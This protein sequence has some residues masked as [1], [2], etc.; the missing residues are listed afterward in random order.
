LSEIIARRGLCLVLAAPSGGGK[1]SIAQALLAQEPALF[2]SVSVTTRA[3]RP[4]EI[5][6]KHYYFRDEPAFMAL[7]EG[8]GLLEWARKFGRCYGTPRAAVETALAAGR[9]VLFDIDWQGFRQLRAAIPDD[10]V[11]IF[12]LPPSLAALDARLR[13]RRGDDAAEI[14]RRMAE[15]Q[16]EIAHWRE[17]DHVIINDALDDAVADVRAILRAGRLATARQ[18]GLDAFAGAFLS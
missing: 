5:E 4:G 17:F 13:A 7:A 18:T 14:A 15:A 3:P 10:L 8:G 6:G 2:L 1:S 11:G 16:A 9:D 12:V